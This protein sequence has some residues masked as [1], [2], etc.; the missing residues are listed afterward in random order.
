MQLNISGHHVDVT[1]S[2]R[3]LITEKCNKLERHFDQIDK[4]HVI[5]SVDKK[6]QKAEATMHLSG[7][8]LFA[9]A[10]HEDLYAAIDDLVSKLDRQVLKHK[11]KITNRKHGAA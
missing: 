7:T 1:D 3:T 4:T 6:L 2:F 11:G 5:I 10:T 8:D 9:S